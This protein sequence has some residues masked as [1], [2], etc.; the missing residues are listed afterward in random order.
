[1]RTFL[2]RAPGHLE[3][4]R[5]S[6]AHRLAWRQLSVVADLLNRGYCA[7]CPF[8]QVWSLCA[9]E[10]Q[11]HYRFSDQKKYCGSRRLQILYVEIVRPVILFPAD[12]THRPGAQSASPSPAEGGLSET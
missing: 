6:R 8:R 12:T 4:T 1:M 5:I 11:R 7:R 9:P 10:W 2:C 3:N